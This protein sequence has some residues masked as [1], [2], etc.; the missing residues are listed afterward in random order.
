MPFGVTSE[1]RTM[2]DARF[3]EVAKRLAKVNTVVSKLDASIR[4]EAFAILKPYVESLASAASPKG[5]AAEGDKRP[6][7]PVDTSSAEEF[8]R[9][10]IIDKPH[11]VVV[12]IAA[13]WFSQY[14]SAPITSADITQIA[15]EI[16]LTVSQRPD[17]SLLGT[18]T[19]GKDV[20][21]TAGRGKIVPTV[22]HGELYLKSQ[23]HVEKGK[24]PR[25]S[26]SDS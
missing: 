21:R 15:D 23:Y 25:P 1:D 7:P 6:T 22:P 16:G 20:F 18:K 14:G 4:T 11:Q 5:A 2:D 24:K 10:Q 19:D 8:V 3:D 17:K 26:D 9:S 13:W 12:A